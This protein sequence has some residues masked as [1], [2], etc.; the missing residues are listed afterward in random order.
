LASR[1]VFPAGTGKITFFFKSSSFESWNQHLSAMRRPVASDPR[2][3]NRMVA[4]S[5]TLYARWVGVPDT[6]RLCGPIRLST[7]ATHVVS[8]LEKRPQRSLE[9]LVAA[10]PLG[11]RVINEDSALGTT[12]EA[13]TIGL[14]GMLKPRGGQLRDLKVIVLDV[15][16][17]NALRGS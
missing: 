14:N 11:E 12:S 7:C 1:Q 6:V 3:L 17:K 16:H 10:E 5:H 9:L 15:R 2:D 4:E 8:R 13:M